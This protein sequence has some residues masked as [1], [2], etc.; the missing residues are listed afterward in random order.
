MAAA[1]VP[2]M[3]TERKDAHAY[4]S[5]KQSDT[6]EPAETDVEAACSPAEAKETKPQ[7]PPRMQYIRSLA[8]GRPA[9]MLLLLYCLGLALV[10]W[11]FSR[12]P[13]LRTLEAVA[14]QQGLLGEGAE[15]AALRL[16]LPHS[17]DELRAVRRTVELYRQQYG[18]QL[19]ALMVGA[20]LFLQAF[21]IPGSVV[22]N[23]LAGSMYTFPAALA[24]VGVVSTC[25]VS[26]N[27]WLT[28]WFLKDVVTNLIPQR[29]QAFSQEVRRHQAHLLN[30][31][32]FL[33][34]TPLLPGWFISLASPIVGV[35][36]PTFFIAS[37]VGHQPL[38]FITVQAGRTLAEIR[39]MRDLYSPRNVVFMLLIGGVALLPVAFKFQ[40]Q[41][42]ERRRKGSAAAAA[43]V[44]NGAGG[45]PK[46]PAALPGVVVVAAHK[47]A[48]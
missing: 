22:I 6:A 2:A 33:R 12:L 31:M 9:L 18:G 17:F 24:F 35:P 27:Y 44:A 1:A 39:S 10:Y 42:R 20:Y 41:K 26:I 8:W 46:S 28:R 25:G 5:L 21:M 4:A 29:V 23:V 48:P 15:V 7:F 11:L 16:S 40:Q 14:R 45:T 13:D 34:A 43:G 47:V 3:R 36:F 30:Y 37:L 32:L 19:L 38:N